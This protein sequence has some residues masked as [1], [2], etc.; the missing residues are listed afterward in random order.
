MKILPRL[1]AM[2]RRRQNDANASIGKLRRI[3][4]FIQMV[5]GAPDINIWVHLLKMGWTG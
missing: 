1:W 3:A 4:L 5:T 2:L